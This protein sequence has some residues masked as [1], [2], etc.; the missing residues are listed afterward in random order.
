MTEQNVIDYLETHPEFFNDNPELT[1]KIQLNFSK[2]KTSSLVEKCIT[3]LKTENK[4]L[5]FVMATNLSISKDNVELSKRVHSLTLEIIKSRDLDQF[6]DCLQY[7]FKDLFTF[8]EVNI[9]SSKAVDNA[10][11]TKF[12]DSDKV[13]SFYQESKIY[14]G[15]K[16]QHHLESICNA[17]INSI[18]MINIGKKKTHMIV[19]IGSTNAARFT[20]DKDHYFINNL[21]QIMEH[22]LDEFNQ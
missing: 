7:K 14:Y 4:K 19:L 12:S 18:V 16:Q 9:L 21:Q 8:D 13:S 17:D 1:H 2:F 10:F 3:N 22:K 5:K 20:P 15:T 6:I 11:I